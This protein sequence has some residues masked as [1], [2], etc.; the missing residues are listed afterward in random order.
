MRQD[1]HLKFAL[2]G[3]GVLVL[4]ILMLVPGLLVAAGGSK[5]D[6]GLQRYIVELQDPPLAQ[7]DGRELS[8][9]SGSGFTRMAPTARSFTGGRKLNTR[10]LE[11]LS[12]LKFIAER[13]EDFK[14][15]AGAELGRKLEVVHEYRN[16]LN[17]M[18]VELSA[19]EAARLADSP[20]VKSIRRE[21]IHRLE[22]YALSLIHI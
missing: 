21:V 19:T 4:L 20:L 6:P 11:S 10:S 5:S 12:Y 22:T 3:P 2:R 14:F 7:Y 13:Q 1:S 15:Q 18:S 17:G 8:V 9:P 16:A